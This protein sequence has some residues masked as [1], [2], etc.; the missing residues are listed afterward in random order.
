MKN[1]Y[2]LPS[3]RAEAKQSLQLYETDY[4]VVPPRN[5][6]GKNILS[7]LHFFVECLILPSLRAIA[8]QSLTSSTSLRT[9]VKQSPQSI[10]TDYFVVP[11]RNDAG[12]SI[13]KIL[14]VLVKTL[15]T[16]SLRITVKGFM[17]ITPSLGTKAK[18]SLIVSSSLRTN[19]KQSQQTKGTDYFVVP[20]RN[21]DSESILSSLQVFVKCLILPSLGTKAKPSLI[22]SSSLRTNVKQSQQTKGTD[23]FVVP[24]RNDDSESIL[25][26]LQVFVKCLILPSLQ[27]IAKQSSLASSSLRTNVKQSLQLKG[28]DYFVVPPRNDGSIL[29]FAFNKQILFN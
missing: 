13:L 5:D 12:K 10:G 2:F 6:A 25:S 9:N 7:L 1:L 14:Q 20:P 3:L 16:M 19:V 18:Q 15:I 21:D 28:T 4:F 27:A 24:P 22:V 29:C 8:K 26:S 23:Y 11:P 17:L